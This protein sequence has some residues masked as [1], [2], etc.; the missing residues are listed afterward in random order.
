VL[1]WGWPADIP[2]IVLTGLHDLVEQ[3]LR[4]LRCMSIVELVFDLLH[5]DVHEGVYIA[6]TA[7]HDEDG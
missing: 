7:L 1:G 3:F 2:I 4:R 6:T 5:H